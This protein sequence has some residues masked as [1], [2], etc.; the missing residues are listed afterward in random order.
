M[1]ST[2][3]F[4]PRPVGLWIKR[5]T[6]GPH[7]EFGLDHLGIEHVLGPTWAQTFLS[8]AYSLIWFFCLSIESLIIGALFSP[9]DGEVDYI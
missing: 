9:Y 4:D 5:A 3:V 1:K 6:G 2:N 7:V 8:T